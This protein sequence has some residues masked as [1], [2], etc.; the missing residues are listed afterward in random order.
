MN[1]FHFSR[2]LFY[3]EGKDLGLLKDPEKFGGVIFNDSNRT[4]NLETT[5]VIV[6]I[7]KYAVG[8]RIGFKYGVCTSTKG[9]ISGVSPPSVSTPV[10]LAL[11]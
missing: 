1:S 5:F 2:P 10:H 3:P 6:I 11:L 7:F 8:M 9:D 4:L